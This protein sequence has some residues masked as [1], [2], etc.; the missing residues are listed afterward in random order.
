MG[1]ILALIPLRTK[2]II[3][4]VLLG[5]VGGISFLTYER[6]HLINEGVEKEKA[7]FA[8]GSAKA[9]K[10][11]ADKIT[12]LT[13]DHYDDIATIEANYEHTIQANDA[14]HASDAE[15]LRAYDAYRKAHPVLGGAGGGTGAT[16]AGDGGAPTVDDRLES[17]EQVALGLATA[18]RGLDAALVLC[19]EDRDH[20]KGK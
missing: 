9:E 20:L 19:E 5:L 13:A 16:P 1:A 7:A 10:E 8:A 15:R 14:A 11:A 12:K 2:V 6:F 18:G 17:L 4:A 3:V